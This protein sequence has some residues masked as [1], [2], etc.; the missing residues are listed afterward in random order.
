MKRDCPWAIFWEL[1]TVLL[2]FFSRSMVLLHRL[3][4]YYT[5]NAA[6]KKVLK[7]SLIQADFYNSW[8]RKAYVFYIQIQYN[9]YGWE[10][11]LIKL[12]TVYMQPVKWNLE[13]VEETEEGTQ[14][15]LRQ[16]YGSDIVHRWEIYSK[17]F[18]ISDIL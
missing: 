2:S 15:L 6:L 8:N 9:S 12:I 17:L 1:S 18:L 11:V 14:C 13:E 5:E 4:K 10:C 16:S 3:E 7:H